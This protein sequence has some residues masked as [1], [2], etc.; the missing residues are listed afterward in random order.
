MVL[1]VTCLFSL[2]GC[3]EGYTEDGEY[4]N[5]YSDLRDI[6]R[7]I[8]TEARKVYLYWNEISYVRAGAFDELSE[9]T[10]LDLHKNAITKVKIPQVSARRDYS[11]WSHLTN[12][13]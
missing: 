11:R 8:P 12:K 5:T 6:P 7:D 10:E 1:A 9:C 13:M 4:H 3:W 2:G